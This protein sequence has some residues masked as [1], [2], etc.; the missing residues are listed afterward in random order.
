M[1]ADAS[2]RILTTTSHDGLRLAARV[3]GA[4][5]TGRP[6]VVCLPGLTRNGRD[7][8]DLAAFL[9]A[10][11]SP[12]RVVALDYRG[13]GLSDRDPDWRNYS[14]ETESRD[15]VAQLDAAGIDA[16]DFVGTSRGGLHMM[17]LAAG[18]PGLIRKAVLNDIGP[19]IERDGLKRIAATIGCRSRHPDWA[20]A[21]AA[22]RAEQQALYPAMNDEGWHRFA[23]QIF[24]ENGDAIVSD[25]DPALDKTLSAIN[26]DAP[27]PPL[28]QLFDAFA[29]IPVLAI[30]GA[31]SDLLSAQTLA[32]MQARHD[33]LATLTVPDQGHAPL[34]WD[35]L[36][37]QTIGQ[38]L[39]AD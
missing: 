28:W 34:L 2:P 9:A 6:P 24:V 5:Q 23:R 20:S 31:L 8:A 1:A 36:T 13:R 10:G 15:I 17:M 27:M 38:F 18:R 29:A 11:D 25:F 26:L 7:F 32:A 19:V 3:W 35:T 37:L 22:L 33:R 14:L 4:E 39:A 16:A 12:R 30:R 21:A